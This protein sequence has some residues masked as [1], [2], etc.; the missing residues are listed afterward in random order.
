MSKYSKKTNWAKWLGILGGVCAI[1]TWVI[2]K[3]KGFISKNNT[4]V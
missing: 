4:T 3:A 1:V 2:P